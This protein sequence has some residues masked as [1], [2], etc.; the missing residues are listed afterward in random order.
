V[1]V[2][3]ARPLMSL[4]AVALVA[5]AGSGCASEGY[6]VSGTNP[7]PSAEPAGPLS[8]PLEVFAA[9]PLTEA[10]TDAKGKLGA[11]DPKLALNFTFDAGPELVKKILASA[12]GQGSTTAD[13]FASTDQADMAQLTAADLVEVPSIFARDKLQ[14]AVVAGNPKKIS[15]LTDLA[16]PDLKVAIVDAGVAV[17]KYTKV[18]LDRKKIVVKPK[19][20][21][22]DAK[23]ALEAITSGQVD[24]AVVYKTDMALAAG[25]QLEGVAIPDGD[26]VVALCRIAVLKNAKN[27]AAAQAFTDYLV[28]GDGQALLTAHGYLAP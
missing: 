9:A 20:A 14:I 13:V 2:R 4:A 10:L 17:G 26:N 28:N 15:T 8:G 25:G 21:P 27:K 23:A 19:A 5:L 12:A 7:S 18:A 16:R 1:L 6:V 3:V 22:A 11:S 24:A